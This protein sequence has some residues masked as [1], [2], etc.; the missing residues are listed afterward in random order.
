MRLKKFKELDNEGINE[1]FYRDFESDNPPQNG[2]TFYDDI[3]G[4]GYYDRHGI[5]TFKNK[6]GRF[7]EEEDYFEDDYDESY[8]KEIDEICDLLY[9][10]LKLQGFDSEID[11]KETGDVSIIIDLSQRE[12]LSVLIKLFEIIRR[13]KNEV[14]PDH[15]VTFE[16]IPLK[17][18]KKN[19]IIFK[20]YI[21]KGYGSINMR[22]Y[23]NLHFTD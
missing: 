23:N 8:Y 1:E 11:Y 19:V 13:I 20:F 5:Y 21:M 2:Y 7:E 10:M 15:R 22:D 14:F 18:S 12:L 3:D 4:E 6:R 9:D 16:I 17:N